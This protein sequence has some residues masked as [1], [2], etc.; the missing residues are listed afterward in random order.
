[1]ENILEDKQ[2]GWKIV[3]ERKEGDRK[4]KK[5]KNLNIIHNLEGKHLLNFPL[6]IMKM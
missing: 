6:K 3:T 1:M 5:I 2:G 4:F